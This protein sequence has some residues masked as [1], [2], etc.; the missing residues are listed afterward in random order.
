D[1]EALDYCWPCAQ[2]VAGDLEVRADLNVDSDAL[3]WCDGCGALLAYR[4]G[5]EEAEAEVGHFE[6]TPPSKPTDWAELLHAMAEVPPEDWRDPP[7]GESQLWDRVRA[8]LAE[9]RDE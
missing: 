4:I 7:V 6:R 5:P 3:R 1:G 9:T 2:D 8:L